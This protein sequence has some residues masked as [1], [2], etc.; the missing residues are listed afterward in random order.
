[1]EQYIDNHLFDYGPMERPDYF[2][3]VYDGRDWGYAEVGKMYDQPP[4]IPLMTIRRKKPK[5]ESCCDTNGVT[6]TPPIPV[7]MQ[8][9]GLFFDKMPGNLLLNKFPH[10]IMR[11]GGAGGAMNGQMSNSNQYGMSFTQGGQPTYGMQWGNS[12]NYGGNGAGVGAGN[13]IGSDDLRYNG[14]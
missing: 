13:G 3:K 7:E 4:Y 12:N 5:E 8:N 9:R 11:Q 2:G 10:F 1:M 14:W 6:E